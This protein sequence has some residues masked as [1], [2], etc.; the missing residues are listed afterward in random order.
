MKGKWILGVFGLIA[1]EKKKVSGK[2]KK[3]YKK[4]YYDM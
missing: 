4:K 2:Q 1:M 3:K